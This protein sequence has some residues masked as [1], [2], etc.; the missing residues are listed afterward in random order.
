MTMAKNRLSIARLSISAVLVALLAA[1]SQIQIPLYPVPINLALL[2]VFLT[3]LLLPPRLAF[4]TV[5]AYLSM[6]LVG[7]PVFAGFK[8][9]PGALF[10]PT[11]GYLLGYLFSVFTVGMLTQR[12]QGF[13]GNFL[14][15]LLGI[16]ACYLPGTLWL[17][18]LTGRGVVEVLPLAVT[19]FVPGDVLK[20][21]AASLMAP[22]LVAAVDRALRQGTR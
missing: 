9:G 12:W 8:G 21:L 18:F 10:G 13:W 15:C 19:P 1:G 5:A 6:G 20:A 17:S 11:G 7:L 16:L 4:L 22:R 14:A 2:V 3:A